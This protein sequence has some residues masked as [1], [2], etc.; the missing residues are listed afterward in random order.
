MYSVVL[1]VEKD[2]IWEKN[3]RWPFFWSAILLL[4][5]INSSNDNKVHNQNTIEKYKN[6]TKNLNLLLIKINDFWISGSFLY[7]IIE[8]R[9]VKNSYLIL[10]SSMLRN[11]MLLPQ[12]MREEAEQGD[13]RSNEAKFDPKFEK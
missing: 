8:L 2:L 7:L 6:S 1:L 10:I 12:A 13:W 3:S 5:L 11:D 4:I 9:T